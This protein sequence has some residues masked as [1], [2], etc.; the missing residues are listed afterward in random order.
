VFDPE[1]DC[2]ASCEI[3]EVRPDAEAL[4]TP[5]T[6]PSIRLVTSVINKRFIVYVSLF[7]VTWTARAE[8]WARTQVPN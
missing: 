6:S 8:P 1:F 3:G 5:P 4:P 7:G 2:V